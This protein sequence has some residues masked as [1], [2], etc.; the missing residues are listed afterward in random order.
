MRETLNHLNRLE[1]AGVSFVSFS[2][3][4]VNSLGVW[5]DAVLG[6]IAAIARQEV[7]RRSE[8][9]KAGMARAKAEGKRVSRSRIAHDK[10]RQIA[11][12]FVDG[13]SKKEIARRLKVSPKTVRNYLDADS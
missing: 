12:L 3:P 5:R 1:S 13:V 7:V 9:V 2:E 4:Y 11:K 10:Q 8:R 6:F